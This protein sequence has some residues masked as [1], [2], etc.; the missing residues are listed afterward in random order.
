MPETTEP[1]EPEPDWFQ[2][3]ITLGTL[4]YEQTQTESIVY[5]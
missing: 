1:K 3:C 2:M 5:T 4:L